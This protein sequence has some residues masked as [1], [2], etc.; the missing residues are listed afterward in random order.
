MDVLS[1]SIA[2]GV[3]DPPPTKK[4][5]S[6]EEMLKRAIRGLITRLTPLVGRDRRR[7]VRHPM[8]LLMELTPVD[9]ESEEPV[10]SPI[11]VVGKSLS[12]QG[13]GFFHQHAMPY[14]HAIVRVEDGPENDMAF[15]VDLAWCRYTRFGW[16]E[17]G[18]RLLKVVDEA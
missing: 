7:Y 11:V 14:R 9:S 4:C 10:G 15:L 12:E 17:S 6:S 3:I 5:E 8:P 1:H 2:L 16:Y 13:I 18:G